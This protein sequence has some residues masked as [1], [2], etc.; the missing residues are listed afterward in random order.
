MK[1]ASAPT[2]T[3]SLKDIEEALLGGN[4]MFLNFVLICVTLIL[5]LIFL[6]LTFESL[7]IYYVFECLIYFVRATIAWPRDM[8]IFQEE[9]E[10]MADPIDYFIE[11]D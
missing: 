11:G 2:M 8:P 7:F 5:C 6:N 4:L 1:G 9:D 3:S 10:D